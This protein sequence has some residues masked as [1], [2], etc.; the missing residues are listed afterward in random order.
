MLRL[1]DHSAHYN[2]V[3]SNWW[4]DFVNVELAESMFSGNSP[5]SNG[6]AGVISDIAG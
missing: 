6:D 3:G 5:Y 1:L 2:K 4:R